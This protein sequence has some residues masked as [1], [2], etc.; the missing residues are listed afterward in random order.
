M[1]SHYLLFPC[2]SWG[3]NA[4]W[5]FNATFPVGFWCGPSSHGTLVL[6]FNPFDDQR[7]NTAIWHETPELSS[8]CKRKVTDIWSGNDLGCVEHEL[9]VAVDGRSRDLRITHSIA[10]GTAF[11]YHNFINEDDVVHSTP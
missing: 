6:M 10:T 5:M 4:D 11:W 2:R 7:N 9:D 8:R 1:H 3:T